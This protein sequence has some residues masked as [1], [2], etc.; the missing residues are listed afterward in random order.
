LIS[1]AK[2]TQFKGFLLQAHN[3]DEEAIGYFE[4]PEGSPSKTL[5]CPNNRTMVLPQI[6]NIDR[7]LHNIAPF[8]FFLC[9]RLL[10]LTSI[11]MRKPVSISCGVLLWTLKENSFLRRSSSKMCYNRISI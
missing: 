8:H 3:A 5:N 4:I 7:L 11:A 2:S 6:S 9:H 1:T 10:L